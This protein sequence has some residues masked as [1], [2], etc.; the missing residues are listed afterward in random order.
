M[1]LV[2]TGL[3]GDGIEKMDR[4]LAQQIRCSASWSMD[5]SVCLVCVVC[6]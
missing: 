6:E 1:S 4:D 2:W 5:E 3:K